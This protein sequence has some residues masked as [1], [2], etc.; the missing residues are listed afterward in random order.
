MGILP[1]PDNRAE[2][3]MVVNLVGGLSRANEWV[4]LGVLLLLV[5]YAVG[6]LALAIGTYL[7]HLYR[8]RAF[9]PSPF[10]RYF[11]IALGIGL[12]VLLIGIILTRTE[13]THAYGILVLCWGFG[14]F[15]ITS[16][17]LDWLSSRAEQ[18]ETP[19]LAGVTLEDV[20]AWQED[21]NQAYDAGLIVR[22]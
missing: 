20:V 2:M 6:R 15:G 4:F 18:Q 10:T 12:A 7:F 9:T 16:V 14:L 11:R 1:D 13:D 8:E 19:L 21:I 22:R 17:I 5:A 3:W